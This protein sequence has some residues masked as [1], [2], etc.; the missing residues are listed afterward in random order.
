MSPASPSPPPS[1]W[2]I[3]EAAKSLVRQHGAEAKAV[4]LTRAAAAQSDPEQAKLWDD[5][6]AAIEKGLSGMPPTQEST[7]TLEKRRGLDAG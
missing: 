3:V 1:Y 2:A 6:A 5:I 7:S 4:A